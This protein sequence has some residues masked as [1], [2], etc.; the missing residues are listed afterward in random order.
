MWC[1]VVV[2]LVIRKFIPHASDVEGY[3]DGVND[4]A[5]VIDTLFVQRVLDKDGVTLKVRIH[6]TGR[7][8]ILAIGAVPT[9]LEDSIAFFLIVVMNE[10]D[11]PLRWLEFHLLENLFRQCF[12]DGEE[13]RLTS[14]GTDM[15]L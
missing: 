1:G 8:A 9:L 11:H 12:S 15:K 4:I 2:G 5:I 10:F 7:T 3:H 13:L 14:T 6:G